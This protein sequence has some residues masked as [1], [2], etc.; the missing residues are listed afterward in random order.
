MGRPSSIQVAAS[1]R[2]AVGVAAATGSVGS[3][4]PAAAAAA[5]AD[6]AA[7]LPL[8][9]VLRPPRA[10]GA[11]AGRLQTNWNNFCIECAR[12]GCAAAAAPLAAAA[13]AAAAQQLARPPLPGCA[14]VGCRPSSAATTVL[15]P[16][17]CARPAGSAGRICMAARCSVWGRRRARRPAAGTR[18]SAAHRLNGRPVKHWLRAALACFAPDL[19]GQTGGRR[20]QCGFGRDKRGR[21]IKRHFHAD[22]FRTQKRPPLEPT[23]SE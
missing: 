16:L 13:A 21:P 3:S 1:G 5:A 20:A 7:L 2:A 23:T 15:A 6:V 17:H 18:M 14:P 12:A 11:C 10:S 19:G 9:I 22:R 8:P 4:E